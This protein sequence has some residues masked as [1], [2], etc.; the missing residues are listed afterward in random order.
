LAVSIEGP[1]SVGVDALA[2]MLRSTPMLDPRVLRPRGGVHDLRSLV[3]D[4]EHFRG[5]LTSAGASGVVFPDS[6]ACPSTGPTPVTTARCGPAGPAPSI[7]LTVPPGSAT[8][9]FTTPQADGQRPF[10]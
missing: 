1:A 6:A 5:V 4:Q 7:K 8:V 2:G 3:A 9:L 10:A